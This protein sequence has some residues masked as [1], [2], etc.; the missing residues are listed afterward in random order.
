MKCIPSYVKYIILSG[1][2]GMLIILS[3]FYASSVVPMGLA[4]ILAIVQSRISCA[5]CKTPLLKDKNGWYIFTMRP[6]CR[7]CGQDTLL[8]EV[9][10]D[11]VTQARLN[12]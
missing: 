4:M 11:E 6:T 1:A 3:V 12:K 9:E 5:K 7:S 10:T 2:V 8:C